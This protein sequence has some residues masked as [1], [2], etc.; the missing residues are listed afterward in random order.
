LNYNSYYYF[1]IYRKV[2]SIRELVINS[3]EI[4]NIEEL[5]EI[6]KSVKELKKLITECYNDMKK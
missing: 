4:I 6:E 5:Y 1:P 2:S 3:G